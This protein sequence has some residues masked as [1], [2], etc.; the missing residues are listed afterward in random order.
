M[1]T[2]KVPWVSI[3]LSA[4]GNIKPCCIYKG[5]EFNLEKGDTLDSAWKDMDELR[6]NLLMARNQTRVPNVGKE[7]QPLVIVEELGMMIKLKIGQTNMN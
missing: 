4:N 5:G 6:Q 3:A 1:P 7:K 2:C